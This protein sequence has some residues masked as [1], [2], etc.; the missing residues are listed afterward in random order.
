MPPLERGSSDF[1]F[2]FLSGMMVW[3]RPDPI[4]VGIGI[5]IAQLWLIPR[6]LAEYVVRELFFSTPILL[7][8][9]TNYFFFGNPM[10]SP[11]YAK[12]WN[13]AFFGIYPWYVDVEVGLTHLIGALFASFLVAMIVFVRFWQLIHPAGITSKIKRPLVT[14]YPR[15]F[16]DAQLIS[17]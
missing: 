16:S 9:G 10:P 12:S 7:F 17:K 4:L 11:F 1:R 3:L 2:W 15:H 13:K 14:E 6:A 8:L 5:F